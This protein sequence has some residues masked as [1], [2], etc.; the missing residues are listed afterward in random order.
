MGKIEI[1]QMRQRGLLDL[2][3]KFVM[4][5]VHARL[6][7]VRVRCSSVFYRSHAIPTFLSSSGRG[8]PFLKL[9][10]LCLE[11]GGPSSLHRTEVCD[12]LHDPCILDRHSRLSKF[13]LRRRSSVAKTHWCDSRFGC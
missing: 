2:C 7:R 12:L 8:Q 10:S 9:A 11:V 1:R 3:W 5:I 6:V 4:L 13:S